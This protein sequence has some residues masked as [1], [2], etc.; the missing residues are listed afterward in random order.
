MLKLTKNEYYKIEDLIYSR[1]RDLEIA[2]LQHHM[3]DEDKVMAAHALTIYQNSDG[4][5][6]L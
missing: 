6:G 5:F 1:A 2:I 4:G 3:D